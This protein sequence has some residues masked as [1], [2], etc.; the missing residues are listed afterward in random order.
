M[1]QL[2]L[3]DFDWNL[4]FVLGS[5]A[6]STIEE[7]L[8]HLRFYLCNNNNSDSDE[9]KEIK[10]IFDLELSKQDLDNFLNNLS[11]AIN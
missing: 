7:P 8:L 3:L 9:S 10:D 5:S 6:I 2:K 1:E 4:Q 11:S